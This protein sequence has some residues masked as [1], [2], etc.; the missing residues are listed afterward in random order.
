MP[1]PL[2]TLG[3][4]FTPRY[5]RQPGLLARSMAWMTFSPLIEYLSFTRICPCLPSTSGTSST[6]SMYPSSLRTCAMPVQI[7]LL[8]ISTMRR[9][10]RFALRIRVNMSA[11]GSWLFILERSPLSWHGRLGHAFA[12]IAACGWARRPCHV[13]LPARLLQSRDL[14]CQREFPQHDPRDLE[15]AEHA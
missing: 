4:S 13:V 14:S 3:S 1:M 12:A 9:P 7:L 11:M 5:T 10:T 2:R 8:G 15:L 6:S